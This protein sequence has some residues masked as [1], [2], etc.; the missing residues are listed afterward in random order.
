[1]RKLSF[2]GSPILYLVAT[3][4]GNLED[5]SYR[6]VRIL[7]EVKKIYCEDTRTSGVLL[8][9]Y[10]I[11]TPCE[12][13]HNFNEE[14]K[15]E[16]IIKYI[17]EGN[18]V[19]LI[20]DAGLPIISDPGF[21]LVDLAIKNNIS[22]TTIPGASA[23]ISAFVSS[24]M[25]LPFLFYGFLKP[26]YSERKRELTDLKYENASI[27]FYEAP[28][29]IKEM[30]EALLEVFGDRKI[31]LARELTKRFEEYLRGKISEILPICD[32]LKGEMVVIC[33]G[34][35]EEALAA[36]RFTLIDEQISLGLK[37][38]QAIKEVANMLNLD[39]KELY[40]EYVEYKNNK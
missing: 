3:P 7:K 31:V 36:D 35:I 21:K 10:G 6:A 14:N 27:I 24:N 30:L 4:I 1:M 12:G 29:R 23:G 37:A 5:I 40:K 16:A 33:H 2:D 8:K 25:P 11:K 26:K 20:S 15:S 18:D 39:K 28:H 22:V 13:Y 19:A 32:T 9:H 38:N 34:Y 17:L